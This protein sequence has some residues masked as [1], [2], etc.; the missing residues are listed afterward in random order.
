MNGQLYTHVTVVDS[1]KKFLPDNSI[2]PKWIEF[3]SASYEQLGSKIK[4][5]IKNH[6]NK[7]SFDCK[8]CKSYKNGS[9]LCPYF[10][11]Y[12]IHYTFDQNCKIL[13]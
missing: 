13:S 4:A 2:N 7:G 8:K 5:K 3:L 1:I 9:P 10:E 12:D 6:Y 11:W